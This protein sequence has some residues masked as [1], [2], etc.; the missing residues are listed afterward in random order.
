M[1]PSRILGVKKQVLNSNTQKL[2][3][4]ATKILNT[5]ESE[6]VETLIRKINQ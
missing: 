3:S 2:G 6:T 4:W 5:K 1:H